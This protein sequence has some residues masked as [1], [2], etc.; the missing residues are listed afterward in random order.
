MP[1]NKPLGKQCC[2]CHFC[3]HKIFNPHKHRMVTIHPSV[4]VHV[5]CISFQSLFVASLSAVIHQLLFD[6]LPVVF[7]IRIHLF[8]FNYLQFCFCFVLSVLIDYSVF[9][10]SVS[11]WN[12]IPG[13][14]IHITPCQQPSSKSLNIIHQ[15]A[16]SFVLV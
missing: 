6:I 5:Q 14:S 13:I 16:P 2:N 12:C 8:L 9:N 10:Y 4:F 11:Y 3:N 15:T 1:H 7:R